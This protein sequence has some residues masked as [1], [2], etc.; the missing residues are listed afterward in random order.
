MVRRSDGELHAGDGEGLL[1]LTTL[2]YGRKVR[3][4]YWLRCTGIFRPMPKVLVL[5]VFTFICSEATIAS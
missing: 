1:S 3:G 5:V 4:M 2:S